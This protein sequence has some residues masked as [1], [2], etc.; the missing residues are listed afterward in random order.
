MQHRA[1]EDSRL[2]CKS[3]MTDVMT[4]HEEGGDKHTHSAPS[5]KAVMEH[6][7]KPSHTFNSIKNNG[8]E[9]SSYLEEAAMVM[10]DTMI[11]RNEV[12]V[13]QGHLALS[14]K[15]M[16]DQDEHACHEKSLEEGIS[17][18]VDSISR[19]NEATRNRPVHLKLDTRPK[20]N[21]GNG[22]SGG[23]GPSKAPDFS[24]GLPNMGVNEQGETL[25]GLNEKQMKSKNKGPRCSN[26]QQSIVVMLDDGVTV[27][28][29]SPDLLKSL[30]LL[31]RTNTKNS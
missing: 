18:G 23:D 6:A 31:P 29:S 12:G 25:T 16:M 7:R 17:S 10:T 5:G 22:R 20:K 24:N 19:L 2:A 28:V 11:A 13:K 1:L 27:A 14:H 15:A 21:R 8:Q 9:T 4:Q 26:T 3:M 30:Q